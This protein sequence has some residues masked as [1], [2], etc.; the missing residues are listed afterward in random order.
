MADLTFDSVNSTLYGSGSLS[1]NLYSINLLTGKATSLGPSGKAPSGVGIAAD[2]SGTIFGTPSGAA[3][4]L[5]IYSTV[6]GSTTVVAPLSGSPFATASINALA[7]NAGTLFGVDVNLADSTR[8]T[9]L[10]TINT[11]TGVITN[12]GASIPNLDAIAFSVPEASTWWA[13]SLA[14]VYIFFLR[15]RQSR[16]EKLSV[17]C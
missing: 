13:A 14:A 2:G 11:I 17:E 5:V 4:D 16:R 8:P 10:I 1:A 6:N 9:D 7:F 12:I 15:L 3:S